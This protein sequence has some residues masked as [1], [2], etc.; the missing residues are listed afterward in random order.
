MPEQSRDRLE[1]HAAVDRLGGQSVSELMRVDVAEI[2]CGSGFLDGFVDTRRR[3][4]T[5]AVG[6]Q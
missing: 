1:A 2:C 5:A 3:D 4:W 6:E